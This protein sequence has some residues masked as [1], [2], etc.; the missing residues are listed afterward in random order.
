MW[1][2]RTNSKICGAVPTGESPS[3][4]RTLDFGGTSVSK[5]K[6]KRANKL[7]VFGEEVHGESL[8]SFPSTYDETW[9]V[10]LAVH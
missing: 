6:A 4:I 7:K 1:S 8:V 2:A 10:P 5:T 9:Y 3:T